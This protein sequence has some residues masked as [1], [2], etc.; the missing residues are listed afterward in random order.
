MSAMG[1]AAVFARSRLARSTFALGLTLIA[2][3]API[4]AAQTGTVLGT[5]TDRG[6]SQPIDAARAQLLGTSLAAASDTRGA[7]VLRGVRPG[8]YSVRVSRIGFRLNRLSLKVGPTFWSDSFQAKTVARVVY[9]C[10]RAA[11]M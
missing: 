2:V 6:T 5:I 1:H 7:F 8:T 3:G 11:T 4:A 9:R 10:T